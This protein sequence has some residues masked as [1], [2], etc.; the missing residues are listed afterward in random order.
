MPRHD[1]RWL[2]CYPPRIHL[3]QS[4][5]GLQ[6]EP[7]HQFVVLIVGNTQHPIL[8]PCQRLQVLDESV[9]GD[10]QKAPSSMAINTS[11]NQ[12]YMGPSPA[13]AR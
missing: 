12:Q 3:L 11:E 13:L 10:I 4:L 9:T 7:S 1:T 6:N 5:K 8:F 2:R